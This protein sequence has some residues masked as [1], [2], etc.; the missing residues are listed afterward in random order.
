[1][2]KWEYTSRPIQYM[3]DK[4]GA[5]LFSTLKELGENGWE[6]CATTK[7]EWVFKRKIEDETT[8]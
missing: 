3:V 6:L 2:T 7:Y 4:Y 1:M 5:V 8:D